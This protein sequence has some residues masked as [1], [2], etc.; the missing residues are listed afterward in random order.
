MG[1]T[2]KD[3][4]E[5]RICEVKESLRRTLD[6]I[7]SQPTDIEAEARCMWEMFRGDNG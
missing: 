3:F 1:N 5:Q 7:R 2:L 6:E 4:M